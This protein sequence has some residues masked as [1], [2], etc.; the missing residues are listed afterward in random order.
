MELSG[1]TLKLYSDLAWY[2]GV[3]IRAV[4]SYR[5]RNNRNIVEDLQ[6]ERLSNPSLNGIAKAFLEN[7][8]I[9]FSCSGD[10]QP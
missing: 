6:K 8:I 7:I 9:L 2:S 3:P 10:P 5:A 4:G 1:R